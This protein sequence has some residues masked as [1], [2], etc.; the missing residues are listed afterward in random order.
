[1]ASLDIAAADDPDIAGAVDANHDSR[2]HIR[3]HR[4]NVER[5]SLLAKRV[6]SRARERDHLLNRVHEWDL[7]WKVRQKPHAVLE[8]HDPAPLFERATRRRSMCGA[9]AFWHTI[10]L[11]T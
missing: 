9:R 6:L 2:G 11:S 3:I 5:A 8:G 10:L 1:M 4:Q 7:L